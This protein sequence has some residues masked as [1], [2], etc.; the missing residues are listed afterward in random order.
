MVIM[1]FSTRRTSSKGSAKKVK[2]GYNKESGKRKKKG[3]EIFTI[4][5]PYLCSLLCNVRPWQLAWT[6]KLVSGTPG[7]LNRRMVFPEA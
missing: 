6:S 7:S 5:E 2:L 1:V 3:A 4:V